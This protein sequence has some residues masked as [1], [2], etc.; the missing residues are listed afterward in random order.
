MGGYSHPADFILRYDVLAVFCP[1]NCQKW[2][3]NDPEKSGGAIFGN[4]DPPEAACL[5]KRLLKSGP[6]TSRNP[7]LGTLREHLGVTFSDFSDFPLIFWGCS[8]SVQG[9]SR[10]IPGVFGDP[11]EARFL[12]FFENC[13]PLFF[14]NTI[15]CNFKLIINFYFVSW[16]FCGKV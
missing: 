10:S 6:W 1:N 11:L 15:F 7:N 5:G 9:P 3:R 2:T 13:T 4:F 12:I 14:C 8:W 16:P